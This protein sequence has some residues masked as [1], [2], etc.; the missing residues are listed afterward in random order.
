MD[1]PW[2]ILNFCVDLILLVDIGLTLRTGYIEAQELVNS[3]TLILRKY[4]KSWFFIDFTT[5]LPLTAVLVWCGAFQGASTAQYAKIPRIMRVLKIVRMMKLF[6]LFKLMKIMSQWKEQTDLLSNIVRIGRFIVLIFLLAHI[7]G[8]AWF[9][10]ASFNRWRNGTFSDGSWVYRYEM[11]FD[12]D[13]RLYLFSF[14]WALTTLRFH[15][16]QT[17]LLK[18][19]VVLFVL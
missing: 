5:S 2:E 17:S 9:T 16:V 11:E 7:S 18:F 1:D 3:P 12:D 6:R 8:C 4:L 13:I 10:T 19:H 15:T 14:Y